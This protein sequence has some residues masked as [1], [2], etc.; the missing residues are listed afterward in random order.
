MHTFS[1]A[2]FK[3]KQEENNFLFY[4]SNSKV[5][6]KVFNIL[7][8]WVNNTLKLKEKGNKILF[9]ISDIL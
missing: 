1:N 6:N 9:S 4:L 7:V 2:Q 5:N 3:V 8:L